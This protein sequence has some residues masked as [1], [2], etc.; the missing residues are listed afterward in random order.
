MNICEFSKILQL[1]VFPRVKQGQQYAIAFGISPYGNPYLFHVQQ[2]TII[3]ANN[4][5]Q[6]AVCYN[7]KLCP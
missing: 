7:K 6:H 3:W 2:I 1:M 5:T 4:P